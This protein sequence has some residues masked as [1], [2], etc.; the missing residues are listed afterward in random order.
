MVRKLFHIAIRRWIRKLLLALFINYHFPLA[1]YFRILP[2]KTVALSLKMII[3]KDQ[4]CQQ[5]NY[6]KN[7][8]MEKETY[9]Q[10]TKYIFWP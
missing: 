4:I 5:N 8:V 6:E 2:T 9:M 3:W 7:F 10:N 1:Q